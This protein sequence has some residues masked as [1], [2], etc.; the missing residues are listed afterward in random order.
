MV[1]RTFI[2]NPGPTN[3]PDS[4]LEAFRRPSV[5]FNTDEFGS[6]VD[7]IFADLEQLF[8]AHRV[9]CYPS[10]GHGAW[11]ATLVNL[12]NPGERFVIPDSG[13]FSNRW[14]AMASSLGFEPVVL[15]VD[16]RRA[17][18]ADQIYDALRADTKRELRGVF[19][20]H[21]ATSVGTVADLV[22]IR[23]AIDAA[24]HPALFVVDA[25]A[26]FATDPVPMRDAG[27]DVVL[28]SS[29]KG[30]MMPPGLSFAAVNERAA[31]HSASVTT[32]RSYWNWADRLEPQW[33]YQRFG[34]TPP[35][36]HL[37]ACRAALDH[38]ASEGGIEAVTARHRRFAT[39]FHRAIESWGPAFEINAVEP[40]ERASAVTCI[41]TEGVDVAALI[42]ASADRQVTI[43]HAMEELKDKGFRIGHLGALNESMVLGVLGGIELAFATLGITHDSGLSAAIGALR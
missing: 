19:V 28:A 14:A 35:E 8:G 4:I 23:E 5:D 37:F 41:R 10:V 9:T 30:L 16:Q 17:P 2:Q 25:I 32:G 34:G 21:T 22:A 18:S 6:F 43:T 11:E 1:G 13:L 36:Q 26:S 40:S 42:S 27:I 33:V 29:Q 31:V 24:D 12:L 39:A 7:E 15:E 20:A 38:I 3:I